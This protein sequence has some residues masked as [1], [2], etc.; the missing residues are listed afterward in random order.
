MYMVFISFLQ[1]EGLHPAPLSL[2]P[3]LEIAWLYATCKTDHN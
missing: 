3:A 1:D 2:S